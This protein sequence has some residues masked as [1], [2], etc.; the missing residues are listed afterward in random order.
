MPGLWRRA[1][2]NDRAR[3]W[4]YD[5]KLHRIDKNHCIPEQHGQNCAPPQT[6]AD[7][8]GLQRSA[9]KIRKKQAIL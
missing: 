3:T 8:T 4:G 9:K 1:L 5:H 7:F 6:Q 2:H